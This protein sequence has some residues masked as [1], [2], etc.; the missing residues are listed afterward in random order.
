MEFFCVLSIG[1]SLASYQVR[2]E[3]KVM[4]KAVLRANNGKRDDLPTEIV[5]KKEG[6]NWQADPWHEELVKSLINAIDN[7]SQ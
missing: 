5:L 4:Y 6:D 2:Q 1:G 7:N 3:S